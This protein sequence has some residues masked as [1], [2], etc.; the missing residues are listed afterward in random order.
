MGT[1]ATEPS[2]TALVAVGGF[3]LVLVL[4]GLVA[5]GGLYVRLRRDG[6]PLREWAARLQ[7]AG[8]PDADVVRI[9]VLWFTLQIFLPSALEG[10][11]LA[12]I[13]QD[14]L[15]PAALAYTLA[16]QGAVLLAI[17][18]ARRRSG[19][20][21]RTAFGWGTLPPARAIGIGVRWCA[22]ALPAILIAAGAW[23]S[24]LQ[25]AGVDIR[26]QEAVLLFQQCPE[27]A[28]RI[29]FL[30][31]ALIGAPLMEELLFRGLLLP[32]AVRALGLRQGLYAVALLFSVV[33]LHV[34]NLV[35]LFVLG[36]ALGAGY[37]ASGNL[38]VPI[39]MH[40]VFNGINLLALVM[41]TTL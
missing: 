23:K 41:L 21:P 17:V 38:W 5:A 12:M 34:P 36:L 40:A 22:I 14:L 8:L 32:A 7:H 35:P 2:P 30:A 1:G 6:M 13:P 25:I 3:Y 33:H 26:D 18:I 31:V 20:V 19:I 37:L 10:A 29:V 11:V 15:A 28:V 16:V 24:L 39:A 27:G 4:T 9:A